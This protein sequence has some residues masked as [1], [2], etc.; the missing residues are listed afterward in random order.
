MIP[1]PPDIIA[2]FQ[3]FLD[4]KPVQKPFQGYYKKWLRFYWDFCQKY[5]H[6]VSKH[7]SLSHFIE[8]LH[9]K[10]QKEYQIKQAS[11]AVSL[12][13]EIVKERPSVA[14]HVTIRK[15]TSVKK[16]EI[17]P[18]NDTTVFAAP[19]EKRSNAV[20]AGPADAPP[21]R[22]DC[23]SFGDQ[24]F[25]E[26]ISK[27]TCQETDRKP[28]GI[29]DKT[30]CSK[31]QTSD[32]PVEIGTSWKFAFDGLRDEIMVR[33]YSPKTLK[34][35]SMWL[36]KFQAFTKSKTFESVTDEDYKAF[37]T[38]LAVK[39]KVSASTQNQ[40]FNAL[41]FFFRHVM[42]R[43]PGDI[44]NVVRAKQKPYRPVVLS[45]REIDLVLTH[46]SHPYDLIVKLL[47]G[48]GLRLF[49][50]L[51]LRLSDFDLDGRMLTVHD[52]KGK[53][54]RSIPLPE[55]V[56]PEIRNQFDVA[57]D[58]HEKDLNAGYA[59]AFLM[60]RLD[61]KYKNAA[62]ELAWQWVFPGLSLTTVRD[63]GEKKRYHIHE[64]HVQRAIRDAV[65]KA[66]L[67][68]RVTAHTFRHSFATHLL[69]ANYD[70]R[71]I[72][73]LLGHSDV[74][75]TMIYTHVI[76]SMPAKEIRS[77]LDFDPENS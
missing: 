65:R 24:K 30:V 35:Y 18:H 68:K 55:T 1:V 71:T 11:D 43:E 44:K 70:I 66:K 51:N 40:A 39:R 60:G 77:P 59:G 49:E 28:S 37:L 61:K 27:T 9:Q 63:T 54:D 45:R 42:K 25:A 36:R 38:F 31:R 20:Q 74:R 67:Y 29:F 46:L 4:R 13:Y 50:C 75:T 5:H 14:E 72:Q 7:E 73:D 17:F 69:Q 56:I 52:G 64:S 62:K 53:K 16:A 12:Y 48:C 47:Y 6:P 21:S 2:R 33:Q 8:K 26:E 3:D 58:L 76:K 19:A 22:T 57:A 15:N 41:L 32:Q 10:K 34:S 23:Q